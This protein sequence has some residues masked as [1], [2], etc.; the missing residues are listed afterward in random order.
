[1]DV[2]C[3]CVY[4][5]MDGWMRDQP[6]LSFFLFGSLSRLLSPLAS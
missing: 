5:W 4:E 3:V 1:M 6:L 2:S